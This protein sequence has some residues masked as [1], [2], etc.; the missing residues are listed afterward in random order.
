MMMMMIVTMIE[1]DSNK[2]DDEKKMKVRKKNQ[3]ITTN[4]HNNNNNNNNND[5]NNQDCKNLKR[6][7]SLSRSYQDL[8]PSK[9]LRHGCPPFS[10]RTGQHMFVEF[11]KRRALN[12]ADTKNVTEYTFVNT[13]ART[14]NGMIGQTARDTDDG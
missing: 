9:P 1:T 13:R 12:V 14:V 3:D 4:K 7:T 6:A 10:I 5:N 11:N 8:G 2:D